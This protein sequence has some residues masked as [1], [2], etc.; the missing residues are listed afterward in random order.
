[1]SY[2]SKIYVIDRMGDFGRILATYDSGT[3]FTNYSSYVDLFTN[4]IDF[5][6]YMYDGDTE[7]T[8]DKYNSVCCY[9]TID[10]FIGWLKDTIN[11]QKS[12]GCKGITLKP[13][14]KFLKA[15]KKCYTRSNL[16]ILH[17]GY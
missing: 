11:F 7:I 3:I 5:R 1:M 17:Y 8:R 4:E 15:L 13:M 14:Y 16:I 12:L 10:E 9:C 2:C 6:V